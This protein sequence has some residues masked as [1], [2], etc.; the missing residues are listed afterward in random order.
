VLT[1]AETKTPRLQRLIFIAI[2]LAF[3]TLHC[4]AAEPGYVAVGDVHGDYEDFVAILQRSGIIDQNHH[5]SGG[6]NTLIQLGDLIGLGPK[7]RQV[8]DL[9]MA[10]E[11]EAKKAGGRVLCLLGDHE[12]LN[13]MG[14]LRYVTPEDYATFVD[15]NS[16]N[17]RRSA[18]QDYSKWREKHAALVAELP[19][20]LK[21]TQEEWM[22]QHP[23]GFF[24]QREAFG[25]NGRYGKWLRSHQTLVRLNGVA[26][27][28][29]GLDAT[30]AEMGVEGINTRIRE[31][32]NVFDNTRRYLT[33]KGFIL[34][35]FT[36][37]EMA[38]AV[39]TQ[40]RIEQ[41]TGAP[42]EMQ[43]RG[44]IAPFLRLNDWVSRAANSPF[45]FGGYDEWTE[46]E[47]DN[48]VP[49][50]LKRFDVNAIVVGHTVQKDHQIRPRFGG[51]VFLIDTG[52]LS[53]YFSGGKASALELEGDG[54]IAAQY[55]DHRTVLR[56][57]I[58]VTKAPA[59]K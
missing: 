39:A 23:L 12:V 34:S 21:P 44:A 1:G 49:T 54:E 42:T 14:D 9:M 58:G 40:N 26:Y 20:A 46:D 3:A 37:Q 6:S 16:E 10:L 36:L 43:L 18:W 27:V 55:L 13:L 50:V 24:E 2:L 52:M 51:K 11:P 4:L 48:Q 35:F 7:S 19:P 59:S 45:R 38:N 17:R 30:T 8:L 15:P 5:W 28:H 29:A 57:A 53:T 56:P 41:K 47:G 31:E 32:I 22:A 33:E 25:P